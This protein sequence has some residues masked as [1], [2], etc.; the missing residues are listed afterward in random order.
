M[1][2]KAYVTDMFIQESD[3]IHEEIARD[4]ALE[5]SLKNPYAYLVYVSEKEHPLGIAYDGIWFE[6]TGKD[7]E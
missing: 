2:A 7:K 1:K 6:Y 5:T 3:G 4:D